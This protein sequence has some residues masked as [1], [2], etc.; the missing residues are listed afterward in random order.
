MFKSKPANNSKKYQA[1][2]V[3]IVYKLYYVNVIYKYRAV[4][5]LYS[6]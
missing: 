2:T 5:Y 3:N 4:N 1:Q 6:P